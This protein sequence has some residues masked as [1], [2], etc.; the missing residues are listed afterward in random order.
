MG[1][2]RY[3]VTKVGTILLHHTLI[4]PPQA[5]ILYFLLVISKSNLFALDFG[6]PT[7]EDFC[8]LTSTIVSNL[9]PE[10]SVL[11]LSRK[12]IQILF[13]NR[14]PGNHCCDCVMSEHS[15]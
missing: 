7:V 1:L 6:G 3:S 11:A 14:V 10:S 8:D 15:F 2:A 12:N 5:A 9:M 13:L 4:S